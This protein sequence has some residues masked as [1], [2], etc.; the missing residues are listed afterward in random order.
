MRPLA[1]ALLLVVPAALRAQQVRNPHVTLSLIAE[2]TAVREG[3]SFRTGVRLQVEP[4]WHVY[5]KNPGESGIATAVT[6]VLPE[7]FRA[8]PLSYPVPAIEDV[9]GI[10]THVHQGDLVLAATIRPTPRPGTSPVRLVARVSYGVCRDVCL[11]GSATLTLDLPWGPAQPNPAWWE[12]SALLASRLPK[13]A[14]PFRATATIRDTAATVTLRPAAGG[15][16][17]AQITFFPEDR[18]VIRGAVSVSVPAGSDSVVLRLPLASSP[19][20]PLRGVLVTGDP[21]SALPTGYRFSV[22]LAP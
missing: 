2:R 13:P 7:G 22:H 12:A 11:P 6:W 14:S 20:G 18:A 1:A 3:E 10:R 19:A 9:A 21:R 5:W 8:G 17:P 4:G 16:R 15:A